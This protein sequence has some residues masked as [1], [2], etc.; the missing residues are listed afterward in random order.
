MINFIVVASTAIGVGFVVF[1]TF[2][3]WF[4]KSAE[5][6][7]YTVLE[8]DRRFRRIVPGV[9]APT[10]AQNLNEYSKD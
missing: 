3:P 1:W 8:N 10:Q 6:P 7:K 4:R 9:N 5:R 2:W